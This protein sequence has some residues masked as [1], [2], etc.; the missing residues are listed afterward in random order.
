VFRRYPVADDPS[1][2]SKIR[3][4]IIPDPEVKP[5]HGKPWDFLAKES[6]KGAVK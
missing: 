2:A 5:P 4:H 1:Q 6:K 3:Y